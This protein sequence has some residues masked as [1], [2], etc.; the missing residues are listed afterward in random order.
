MAFRLKAYKQLK[1]ELGVFD[2]VVEF[3]ELCTRDFIANKPTELDFE[4][5]LRSKSQQHGIKVNYVE[6]DKF[7]VTMSHS[8]I[9]IAYQAFENFIHS[10]RKENELIKSV[11]Y[12]IK[13]EDGNLL[14]RNLK[15]IYRINDISSVVNQ[16]LLDIF[17]YYRNVRNKFVHPSS[18]AKKVKKA[19]AK[20]EANREV[21]QKTYRLEA[22]NAF[23][24]IQF[25]DFNLFTR[26]LKQIGQI[27]SNESEPST[28]ELA[29]YY[30]HR[31]LFKNQNNIIR[32]KNA[33]INQ[34]INDFGYDNLDAL[35]IYNEINS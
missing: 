34:I 2:A 10:S 22:P 4:E 35:K 9:V 14:E 11:K 13:T 21:I 12:E 17:D 26:I 5:Y 6:I 18:D 24:E 29:N 23:D 15:S 1:S 8:Y 32:K 20:L 16:R 30:M 25:D 31:N 33:I 28:S 27:I 19:F 7:N 3:S